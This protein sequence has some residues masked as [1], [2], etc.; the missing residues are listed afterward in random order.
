MLRRSFVAAMLIA[1]SVAL[2]SQEPADGL[3]PEVLRFRKSDGTPDRP[4]GLLYRPNVLSAL[5]AGRAGEPVPDRIVQ[6]IQQQTAIVVMWRIPPGGPD[7]DKRG[8]SRTIIWDPTSGKNVIEPI[9]QTAD[10][11]DVRVID[12]HTSFQEVELVAGFPLAEFQPGRYVLL[13]AL[14]PDDPITG[15]QRSVNVIGEFRESRLPPR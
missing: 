9:W 3:T 8:L 4:T 1:P 11:D 10:A 14:L 6:A 15:A 5:I 7:P 12:P 13:Y 2:L